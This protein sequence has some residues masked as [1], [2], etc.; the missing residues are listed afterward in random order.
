M[1]RHA[2]RMAISLLLLAAI[3]ASGCVDERASA[4]TTGQKAPPR[5]RVEMLTVPAGTSVIAS[6]VTPLST[7]TNQT[8]DPFTATTQQPIVV[9]GRTVVASGST[10]RGVLRDVQASGR[11][12]GRAGMTLAFQEIVD[13]HGRTHVISAEPLIL[14]ADSEKTGDVEKI[15]AGG[16]A[17]AI[18]GGITG[19]KK[20]AL[21]GTAV[22][23]GAGTIV[24][25][26]TKGDDIELSPGQRL[27]VQTITPTSIALAQN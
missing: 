8:G 27:S 16:V 10:V 21:I 7:D 25:L 17:G 1:M 11:V 19:G 3:T 13:T 24:V 22:G 6:L 18:I 4:D 26:A 15:A 12:K 23:A 5:P 9:N 2:S 14:Q 20:G